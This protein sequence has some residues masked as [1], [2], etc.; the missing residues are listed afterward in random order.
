MTGSPSTR[1]QIYSLPVVL[2]VALIAFHGYQVVALEDDPQR[3]GA[4]A[5]FATIDIGA[6]RTVIVTD[7]DGDTVLELPPSLDGLRTALLDRPT[8][9]A[10]T[11]LAEGVLELEWTVDGDKATASAAGGVRFDEVHL[12]VVGFGA[13]GRT[14]TR[15]VMTEV[16][17][18]AA[19]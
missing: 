4:F 7:G 3:G 10:A 11:A 6:T 14:I 13:D 18:E 16:V 19:S 9:Q 5:M 8:E 12:R 15:R 1:S 2:L 17:V